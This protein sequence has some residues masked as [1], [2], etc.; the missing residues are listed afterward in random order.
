MCNVKTITTAKNPELIDTENRLVM[1]RGEECQK[2]D[3]QVKWE[4]RYELPAIK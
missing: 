1:A 2:V 4:K 3:I